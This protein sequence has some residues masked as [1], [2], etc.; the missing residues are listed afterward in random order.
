MKALSEG[1]ELVPAT[2]AQEPILAN[3]LELY[4]H[5]FSEFY[6][7]ELGPDGRFGYPQ[8]ESYWREPQRRP[9]LVKVAGQ[10][11]GLALVQRTAG[12]VAGEPVWDM[13]EFFVV[14]GY[15]RRGI[16]SGIA[17]EIWRRHP[18]RWEVRVLES[19]GAALGFWE[20]AIVEFTG[21]ARYRS[22]TDAGGRAWRVF[23]FEATG[24]G[25]SI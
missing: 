10:L 18:G 25:S 16:G 3:L 15:R 12:T 21:T 2:R 22:R 13:A 6:R 8:L 17:Q 23:G 11:A 20:R 24:P 1:W 7:L 9:F 14:R 5:D 4:A 19:N